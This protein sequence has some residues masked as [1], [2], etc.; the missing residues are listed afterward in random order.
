MEV[1][2]TKNNLPYNAD[3]T[4]VPYFEDT[5][6][7]DRWLKEKLEDNRPIIWEK[8]R[9]F[10]MTSPTEMTFKVRNNIIHEAFKKNY[11]YTKIQ[12]KIQYWHI[13]GYY[14]RN[15][16]TIEYTCVLDIYMNYPIL[17][18][19]KQG[20]MTQGHI[21]QE[22]M[23]GLKFDGGDKI[24]K[25]EWRL[26]SLFDILMSGEYPD[27]HKF[28]DFLYIFFS[29]KSKT[30]GEEYLSPYIVSDSRYDSQGTSLSI[31]YAVGVL[32]MVDVNEDKIKEIFKHCSGRII[33]AKI[34]SHIP[35]QDITPVNGTWT[36][37]NAEN[38]RTG[39]IETD[40]SGIIVGRETI[41]FPMLV[42]N[43]PIQMKS[44]TDDFPISLEYALNT[45]VVPNTDYSELELLEGLRAWDVIIENNK[46]LEIPAYTTMTALNDKEQLTVLE[47][48]CIPTPDLFSETYQ[49]ANI[50]ITSDGVNRVL[51]T[52]LR[53]DNIIFN[54]EKEFIF[55][56]NA[57]SAYKAN[58]PISSSLELILSPMRGALM[59]MGM[60]SFWGGNRMIGGMR[61]DRYIK[62]DDWEGDIYDFSGIGAN[63]KGNIDLHINQ[64]IPGAHQKVG[65]QFTKRAKVMMGFG[66]A[67]AG[68]A[69]AR[70]VVK[71]QEM[72]RKPLNVKGSGNGVQDW[73]L[74]RNGLSLTGITYKFTTSERDNIING[75]YKDGVSV[76]DYVFD[77]FEN[78]K[79]ER[80]NVID[81]SNIAQ[82]MP[83]DLYKTEGTEICAAIISFY[84]MARRYWHDTEG[85]FNYDFEKRNDNGERK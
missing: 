18:Q 24:I 7:R 8:T 81:I 5:Q 34:S 63:G 71:R 64:T 32:E 56:Q 50:R 23:A 19:V 77:T 68:M 75:I 30:R 70:T 83:Q 57:F 60:G 72:K 51:V 6:E 17:S 84:T 38:M 22:K 53:D 9:S 35:Y 62:Y 45:F 76:G 74:N 58:N 13:T 33:G 47:R 4:N 78:V 41:D 20:I 48:T 15:A 61:E 29:V 46:T 44:T 52:A 85:M 67:G 28:Q 21:S 2:I 59:G 80:F 82:S 11:C 1:Y 36:W 73:V 43:Y 54:N 55:G 27:E 69:L 25:G 79:R 16:R 37:E 49:P 14:S 10:T 40:E 31:P 66:A 12:G 26:S 39:A 3:S 42:Y 65:T